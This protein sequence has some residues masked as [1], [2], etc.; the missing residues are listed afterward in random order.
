M[1]N[2]FAEINWNPGSKDFILFGKSML[3]GFS[4]ISL[5]FLIINVFRVPFEKELVLPIYIFTI[6]GVLFLIANVGGLPARIFYFIWFALA[7]TIGVIISNLLLALFYY[8]FF[9]VFAFIFRIV[10]GRDPLNI[11]KNS[12]KKS[13]W[14][15]CKT[16][17]SL[18]SY[19]KQY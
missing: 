19:F 6:G 5:V 1:I 18:K 16:K 10:S 4:I 2:P 8:L 3:I 17:K 14:I 11:K 12:S 13:M 7:A 15:D 9:S